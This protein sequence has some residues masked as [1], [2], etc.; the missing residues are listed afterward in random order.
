MFAILALMKTRRDETVMRLTKKIAPLMYTISNSYKIMAIDTMEN[1]SND[2][3]TEFLGFLT[4]K[5]KEKT[6]IK[7][8]RFILKKIEALLKQ[9]EYQT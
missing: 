8:K 6:D 7:F 5:F 3:K 4:N 9:K 1:L 2:S